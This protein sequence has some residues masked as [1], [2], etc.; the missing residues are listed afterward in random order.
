[1]CAP[2]CL[3]DSYYDF[4]QMRGRRGWRRLY[5]TAP[6]V[7]NNYNAWDVCAQPFSSGQ[8]Q[9]EPENRKNAGDGRCA[10]CYQIMNNSNPIISTCLPPFYGRTLYLLGAQH[11]P[12]CCANAAALRPIA[13]QSTGHVKFKFLQ[14]DCGKYF[15]GFEL[16]QL[17]WKNNRRKCITL[18]TM[19]EIHKLARTRIIIMRVWVYESERPHS[20]CCRHNAVVIS[21]SLIHF[22]C[23]QSNI[24]MQHSRKAELNMDQTRIDLM[25]G[26]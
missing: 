8:Q 10:R 3:F 16:W 20:S 21:V 18:M 17:T 25:S 26:Q 14:R 2:G 24:S 12:L 1:M 5:F 4:S 22:S 6:I 19:Y 11:F 23:L 9:Q 13:F 7:G 15:K